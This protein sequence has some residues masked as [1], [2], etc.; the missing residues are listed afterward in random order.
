MDDEHE[1]LQMKEASKELASLIS[2]LILGRLKMLIEEYV[3]LITK[4][5]VD[6][7][8]NMDEFVDLARDI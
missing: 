2:T 5:I 3:Q 4:E 7:E 6:A 8:Y 1:K